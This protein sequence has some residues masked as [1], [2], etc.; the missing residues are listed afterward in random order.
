MQSQILIR[1]DRK[2]DGMTLTDEAYT[3]ER[4]CNVRCGLGASV[5]WVHRGLVSF[6]GTWSNDAPEQGV[7]QSGTRIYAGYFASS[8]RP[9]LTE[10]LCLDVKD[11]ELQCCAVSSGAKYDKPDTEE[12]L[13]EEEALEALISLKLAAAEAATD[14]PGPPIDHAAFLPK[15]ASPIR[16][17]FGESEGKWA[18]CVSPWV[19]DLVIQSAGSITKNI[20]GEVKEL[21]VS[22]FQIDESTLEICK[23]EKLEKAGFV[24]VYKCKK[25][26]SI[27]ECGLGREVYKMGK[28]RYISNFAAK[29]EKLI[30]NPHTNI[31]RVHGF[32]PQRSQVLTEITERSRTLYEILHTGTSMQR[33]VR[34][35]TT[36]LITVAAC[37]ARGLTHMH[38]LGLVHG[39]V[40]STNVI[41]DYGDNDNSKQVK[42]TEQ[43]SKKVKL[44]RAGNQ[45]WTFHNDGEE[46]MEYHRGPK[47]L[48]EW[49]LLWNKD[50][51]QHMISVRS[52]TPVNYFAPEVFAFPTQVPTSL[53]DAWSFGV[54]LAE[55]VSLQTPFESC[56]PVELM[57]LLGNNPN[58]AVE[59]YLK[60][61]L[62]PEAALSNCPALSTFAELFL[63]V[64]PEQR[65]SLSELMV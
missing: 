15:P 57:C 44:L 27:L 63:H 33:D 51:L 26:E 29:L 14:D 24:S 38:S 31:A 19:W 43:I 30:C 5:K 41:F 61:L 39:A 46:S 49:L 20:V 60:P 2:H 45:W 22:E 13:S 11:G 47:S 17:F 8:P 25:T 9:Y 16:P 58:R 21:A 40:S 52:F 55:I 1:L 10:G 28:R 12:I 18:K 62:D 53:S 64:D 32:L 59:L 42:I 34:V 7:M 37:V 23:S 48:D 65:G 50:S 35:K 54:L 4:S 56:T 6:K 36:P 3:G